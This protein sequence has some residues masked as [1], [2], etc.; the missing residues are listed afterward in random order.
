[1]I[2]NAEL[3]NM[4]EHVVEYS[5]A[6]GNPKKIKNTPILIMH[7][8]HSNC[9]ETFGYAELIEHGY[10]VITPSRAGYGRTSADLGVH[11]STACEAYIALLNHLKMEQ[12][13]LIGMSAGGPSAV[14]LAS[15]YPD[16]IKSLTLESAV[17]NEWLTPKDR[18]YKAAKILFNPKSERYTWKLMSSISIFPKFLFRQMAPSF[19]TWPARKIFRDISDE[20]IRAFVKMVKRQRSGKGFMLDIAQSGEVSSSDLQSIHCP[21]LILHSQNDAVVPLDH[22]QFAHHH[23]R[24]AELL[25]SDIWGHLLWLGQGSEEMNRRLIHFLNTNDAGGG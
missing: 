3:F 8:G 9:N 4:G 6:L 7:G 25:I 23:I 5:I 24:N 13:H 21:T 18:A 22:P 20:D 12:V 16:R 1:M 17:T 19:S 14:L 11:L 15:R 2:R 10:T